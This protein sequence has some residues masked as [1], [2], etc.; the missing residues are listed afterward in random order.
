MKQTIFENW[1]GKTIDINNN[2]TMPS[3][4]DSISQNL[5]TIHTMAVSECLKSY[6]PNP[7]LAQ[8]APNINRKKERRFNVR[9]TVQGRCRGRPE[10]TERGQLR[11]PRRSPNRDP[12]ESHTRCRVKIQNTDRG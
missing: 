9:L 10:Y 8:S 2:N 6:K 12:E 11:Q 7:I 4:P 3:T 5:K 1:S